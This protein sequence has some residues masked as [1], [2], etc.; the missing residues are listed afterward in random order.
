MKKPTVAAIYTGS[1]LVQPGEHMFRE[2]LPDVR[3]IS[4]LDNSLIAE[5]IEHERMTEGVL[6]RLFR[7][8][9][10]ALEEGADVILETC[11]SVG[12][13]VDYLQPFFPIPIL[14][15]D[16]PMVEDVVKEKA[17]IGVLATLPTTLG[18]TTDLIQQV[19][20]EKHCTV[21]VVSGLAEGAF[22]AVSEGDAETHDKL[23]LETAM[24]I[25]K[26]CDCLV[27]AQGSM[28]RMEQVLSDETGLPVYTS[29]RRGIEALKA[30]L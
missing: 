13:S 12:N 15:I 26:Q 27:L 11:S 9:E 6:R 1:A 14:R 5:V 30:Y 22:S 24:N 17:H 16:R 28:A 8:C 23:I 18:P 21:T 10:F 4:M 20:Q 19:A 7:L 2:V 25:A 3:S 29:L